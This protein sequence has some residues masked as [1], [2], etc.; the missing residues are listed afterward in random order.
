MKKF[1]KEAE[2]EVTLLTA[3][4]DIMVPSV[5]FDVPENWEGDE[6]GN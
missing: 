6:D 1:F 4:E 2:V 3:L 5:N